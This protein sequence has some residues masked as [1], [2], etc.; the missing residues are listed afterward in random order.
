MIDHRIGKEFKR[1]RKSMRESRRKSVRLRAR[2]KE[3]ARVS[4]GVREG[5]LIHGRSSCVL[6]G[7]KSK[8]V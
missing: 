6:L 1:E 8:T 5:G 7:N 2:M 4:V 3:G